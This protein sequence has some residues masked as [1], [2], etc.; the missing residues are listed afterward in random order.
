MRLVNNFTSHDDTSSSELELH[1][2]ESIH[3]NEPLDLTFDNGNFVE[4]SPHNMQQILDAK[5]TKELM[6]AAKD[7]T[8]FMQFLTKLYSLVSP[9]AGDT[10][11]A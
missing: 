9:V 6:S 7:E 11:T 4:L 2:R 5:M 8:V 3:H 1:F 10:H